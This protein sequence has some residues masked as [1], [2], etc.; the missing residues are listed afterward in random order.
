MK[1]IISVFVVICLAF[2]LATGRFYTIINDETYLAG[3]NNSKKSVELG[4][5]RGTIFD[6]NGKRLTNETD[7]YIAVATSSAKTV[8]ALS[9]YLTQS[10]RQTLLD[11]FPVAVKVDKDFSDNNVICTKIPK[12]YSGIA[13]HIIGYCDEKGNGICGI[14]QAFNDI[15]KGE[16]VTASF[17]TNAKGEFIGNSGTVSDNSDYKGK[18]IMLTIDK[19]LQTVCETIAKKYIEKG[20]IIVIENKTGKIRAMVSSPTYD[21]YDVAAALDSPASPFFNRALAAY[22]CGSVFKLLVAS[23]ALYYDID[24]TVNCDGNI[25][26]GKNTFNCLAEHKKVGMKKAL[27]VSCN[28][29]FIKL[30]QKIGAKRLLSF[31][32]SFGFGS[33]I[34]LC[35][36]LISSGATLPE[37]ADLLNKP[38]EL[39]NFSFGQGEVL[40]SPLQIASMIQCIANGGKLIKPVLVEGVTDYEGKLLTQ[41]KNTLPTYLLQ[42]ND[43]DTLC[44]YMINAVEKGT[45]VAAKP[46]VGGAGGKTAT[47]QTGIFD[48]KGNAVNQTWFGGFYPAE[49]PE[50]TI[51]VLCENG[52]SGGSTAAPVFKQ[53]ADEIAKLS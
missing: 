5:L 43:T 26:I 53:I 32:K 42:E 3:I 21:P 37:L 10:D 44:K 47:A 24:L 6:C 18:G 13:A 28:C 23:A 15:L 27:A 31:A 20:S 25:N 30:G 4:K 34:A 50:Y 45:G 2:L 40:T 36:S 17:T 14:E 39:A 46:S 29:Y 38:A 48:E 22:N 33:E 19:S 1:R 12:R 11:G 16:T 9:E 41:T 7:D 51:V 35:D 49:N 52:K 8:N